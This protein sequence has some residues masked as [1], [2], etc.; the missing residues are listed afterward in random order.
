VETSLKFPAFEK[1]FPAQEKRISRAGKKIATAGNFIWV[2][3]NRFST[4]K[5]SAFAES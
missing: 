5:T 1:N 3:R 4:T 2:R